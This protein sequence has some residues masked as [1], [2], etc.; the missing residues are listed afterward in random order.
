MTEWC[1]PFFPIS[2]FQNKRAQNGHFQKKTFPAENSG[3]RPFKT[4]LVSR[5][6]LFV[7]HYFAISEPVFDLLKNRH[8]SKTPIL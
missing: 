6:A 3:L 5:N 8:P 2:V 1:A 7:F 4:L